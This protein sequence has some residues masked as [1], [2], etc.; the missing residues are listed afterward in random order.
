MLSKEKFM[1]W[2]KFIWK[3]KARD[4]TSKNSERLLAQ[5]ACRTCEHIRT[6]NKQTC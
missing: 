2:K 1:S 3:K 6:Q 5:Q 4:F